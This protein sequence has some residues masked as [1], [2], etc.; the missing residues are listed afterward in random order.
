MFI[1][2]NV[3]FHYSEKTFEARPTRSVSYVATISG[4]GVSSGHCVC[5]LRSGGS[6]EGRQC[7]T[8][9][10]RIVGF[11]AFLLRRVEMFSF[12]STRLA[13]CACK[14]REKGHKERGLQRPPFFRRCGRPGQGFPV[15][16]KVEMFPSI[17]AF[18][19]AP[20]G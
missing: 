12:I 20:M 16:K 19:E 6:R 11:D 3:Q 15:S 10:L 5:V 7:S 8:S 18:G 17:S 1:L 2:R 13:H 4:L 14:K 9:A